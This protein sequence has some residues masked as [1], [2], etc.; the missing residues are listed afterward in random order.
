[1]QTNKATNIDQL[2]MQAMI[3]MKQTIR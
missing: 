3:K 2:C 1:M